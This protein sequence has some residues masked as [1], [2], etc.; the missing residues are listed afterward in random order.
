MSLGKVKFNWINVLNGQCK[1]EKLIVKGK[2]RNT[3]YFSGFG[4]WEIFL[5][6]LPKAQT[7]G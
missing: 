4:M 3:D 2:K 7:L 6:Q 1:S 5:N